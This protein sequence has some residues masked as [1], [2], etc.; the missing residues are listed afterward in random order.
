MPAEMVWTL[1][2]ER[3]AMRA[4]RLREHGGRKRSRLWLRWEDC[5]RT[6]I[7]KVGVVGEWSE[8][9]EDRGR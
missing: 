5:V 4:D 8:L 2:E 3:M 6:D 9:A 7:H 1:G